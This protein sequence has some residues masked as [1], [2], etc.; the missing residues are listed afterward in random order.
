MSPGPS[1]DMPATIVVGLQWGDRGSG[2]ATDLLAG[3]RRYPADDVMAP[4]VDA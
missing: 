4:G 2:A 1:A 3:F